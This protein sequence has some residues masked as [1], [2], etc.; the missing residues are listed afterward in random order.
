MISRCG[1]FSFT[2]TVLKAS[3]KKALVLQLCQREGHATRHDSRGRV[4]LKTI[5]SAYP[6]V[7]LRW[8]DFSSFIR[9]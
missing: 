3:Y 4:G 6:P 9:L 7:D 8:I 2:L 5:G 1:M